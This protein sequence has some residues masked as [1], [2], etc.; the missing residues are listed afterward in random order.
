MNLKLATLVL[1][2]S[3]IE[4]TENTN[5]NGLRYIMKSDEAARILQSTCGQY[6]KNHKFVQAMIVAHCFY[7]LLKY[8]CNTFA[9]Q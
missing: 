5:T 6:H 8:F 4:A 3:Q 1:L 7:Y 2:Y 9:T